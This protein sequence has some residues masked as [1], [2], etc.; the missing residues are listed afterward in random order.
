MTLAMPK[1]S[2]FP[3]TLFPRP[4]R[5]ASGQ[6][7]ACCIAL[8]PAVM[9]RRSLP[10]S[11]KGDPT[12][13][14][15]LRNRSRRGRGHRRNIHGRKD[16]YRQCPAVR[17]DGRP[18]RCERADRAGVP[19]NALVIAARRGGETA[20]SSSGSTAIGRLFR[21]CWRLGLAFE[22]S[23][24]LTFRVAIVDQRHQ[25]L[26]DDQGVDHGCRRVSAGQAWPP[27]AFMVWVGVSEPNVGR[28]RQARLCGPAV[29]HFDHPREMIGGKRPRRKSPPINPMRTRCGP[30]RSSR[31]RKELNQNHAGISGNVE[32][33]N[34]RETQTIKC[35]ATRDI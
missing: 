6:S 9:L 24:R 23:W 19:E 25:R 34:A 3:E 32:A 13:D 30:A 2:G 4:V 5:F 27:A 16:R 14:G 31:R 10:I 15:F 1:V 11:R 21:A 28:G 35:A 26:D 18:L 12:L 33:L 7:S 8:C 20:G 29:R 22:C 17:F